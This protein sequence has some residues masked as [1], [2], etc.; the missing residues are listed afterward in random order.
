MATPIP[1]LPPVLATVNE[2][3]TSRTIPALDGDQMA[4]L[5]EYLFNLTDK[6]LRIQ[7]AE[8]AYL[9]YDDPQAL[10]VFLAC[11]IP[12][13]QKMSQR[14]AYKIHE[15]PSAWMLEAMYDGAVTALL[16]MFQR[17]APLSDLPD[18]FRALSHDHHS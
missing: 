8:I 7:V 4:L 14:R 5:S 16:T 18:A 17:H 11:T 9:N 6:Q 3:L 12:L 15:Y 10:D 2:L 13:A 1:F